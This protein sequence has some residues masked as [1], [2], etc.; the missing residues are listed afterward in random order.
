ML[1]KWIAHTWASSNLRKEEARTQRLLSQYDSE[2][3]AS[4]RR[5][6]ARKSDY[7]RK[8]SVE[9]ANKAVDELKAAGMQYNDVSPA[10]Q[11]RM[12][13]AVKPTI[14]KFL[15]SYDPAIQ[16]LFAS[17]TARVQAIK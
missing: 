9:A 1:L 5:I 11:E 15:N 10:E 2:K 8:I 14:E 17:E 4:D 6:A 3:A 12:R 7:Q 13:Q 16:K